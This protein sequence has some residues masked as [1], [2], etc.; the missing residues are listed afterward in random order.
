MCRGA[1]SQQRPASARLDRRQ[2]SRFKAWSCVPDP[3]NP[4]MNGDQCTGGHSLLDLVSS[5]SCAQQFLS[6][7]DAMGA[8]G[9]PRQDLLD[10]VD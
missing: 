4:A 1:S 8:A 3:E 7:H 9:K 6:G 10:R 5:H 2:I